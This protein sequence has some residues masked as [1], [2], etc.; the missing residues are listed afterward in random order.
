MDDQFFPLTQGTSPELAGVNVGV[1]SATGSP[2][3]G[4][5][6]WIRYPNEDIRDVTFPFGE[7]VRLT[8]EIVLFVEDIA[9]PSDPAKNRGPIF[10]ARLVADSTIEESSSLIEFWER[11]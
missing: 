2:P 1:V 8:D 3:D 5:R 4:V 9:V 10:T 11:A 7:C 6:L